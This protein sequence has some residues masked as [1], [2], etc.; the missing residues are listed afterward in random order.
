M[1][2]LTEN[3]FIKIIA[4]TIS[5]LMV[6][7]G[8]VWANP[9]A[10]QKNTLQPY[11]LF[12]NP[13][14]DNGFFSL[15][16]GYLGFYLTDVENDPRNR[17]VAQM[18]KKVDSALKRI[19]LSTAIPDAFKSR[20]PDTA[21]FYPR[22]ASVVIDLGQYKIRYFNHNIPETE[23]PDIEDPG[24]SCEVVQTH[25]GQYLSRQIL[26]RKAL[27]APAGGQG[28]LTTARAE[29]DSSDEGRSE[30]ADAELETS[31]KAKADSS[32]RLEALEQLKIRNTTETKWRRAIAW[33]SVYMQSYI[34]AVLGVF[35]GLL[36]ESLIDLQP[37]EMTVVILLASVFIAYISSMLV[38]WSAYYHPW[39]DGLPVQSVVVKGPYRYLRHP[40]YLALIMV[41]VALSMG[42]YTLFG[43][44]SAVPWFVLNGVII[45]LF[46]SLARAEEEEMTARF[47]EQYRRVL[48]RTNRWLPRFFRQPRPGSAPSA[49]AVY[50]EKDLTSDDEKKESGAGEQEPGRAEKFDLVSGLKE[51]SGSV[52]DL[53]QEKEVVVIAMTGH[54][55][56]GKTT[57]SKLLERG[58]AGT[59][60]EEILV[61]EQDEIHNLRKSAEKRQE[62]FNDRIK[63]DGAGKK[64]IIVEGFYASENF[65]PESVLKTS[66]IL[67][68]L[69]ADEKI[70]Q[71]RAAK[72]MG[73]KGWL[74]QLATVIMHGDKEPVYPEAGHQLNISNNIELQIIKDDIENVLRPGMAEEG[75]SVPGPG[76][77]WHS[78]FLGIYKRLSGSM[79][80]N[81]IVLYSE[82]YYI[83]EYLEKYGW[84]VPAFPDT[85]S[86]SSGEH[87][88]ALLS[89]A[90]CAGAIKTVGKRPQLKKARR[91]LDTGPETVQEGKGD[92]S[93][94][95]EALEELSKISDKK[96]KRALRWNSI[97]LACYFFIQLGII[98]SGWAGVEIVSQPILGSSVGHIGGA[99]ALTAL[100]LWMWARPY[101]PW[102]ETAGVTPQSLVVRGPYRY[103]R[104]PVYSAMLMVL[105]GCSIF[106]YAQAG[107]IVAAPLF[108]LN[109]VVFVSFNSLARAE[110]EELTARFGEEYR[111][112]L[113]RTYRWLPRLFPQAHLIVL[114]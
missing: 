35:Y 103:L 29:P 87:G 91:P 25:V 34:L 72:R 12:T 40:Y 92:S 70:R 81:L 82:A 28:T 6:W 99:L 57:V 95:P 43:P 64:I 17:N 26:I 13:D 22:K 4:L 47:G 24:D 41:P 93:K 100:G 110:E 3:K 61:I 69:E 2:H 66:D 75:V 46:D 114:Y 30:D 105:A 53:L 62:A 16:S 8:I 89:L 10:F 32:K 60:K 96:W 107:I 68:I 19:K 42:I 27:P 5:I 59:R 86:V 55:G 36:P 51:L 106:V 73:G 18:R 85:A 38:A 54:R 84:S 1:L 78:I 79:R 63:R 94:S 102:T 88:F 56:A 23:I 104:H 71:A 65:G 33:Y 15:I 7:Q 37:R 112:S 31:Q 14:P 45:K 44:V 111:R 77:R 98:L 97:Y 52:A 50:P 108:V 11:T 83:M 76:K 9:D 48:R 49:G 80:R 109:S 90:L 21:E 39:W 67:V 58:F 20:I 74:A 101:H 113:R